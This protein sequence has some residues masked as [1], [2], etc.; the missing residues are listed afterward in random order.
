[1]SALDAVRAVI[2]AVLAH[3]LAAVE[4]TQPLDDDRPTLALAALGRRDVAGALDDLRDVRGSLRLPC[5]AAARWLEECD[6]ATEVLFRSAAGVALAG[7]LGSDAAAGAVV[8][9]LC[10][11]YDAARGHEALAPLRAF[12][13]ALCGAL[14]CRAEICAGYAPGYGIDRRETDLRTL[15]L[16]EAYEARYAQAYERRADARYQREQ[17]CPDRD[18]HYRQGWCACGYRRA[19]IGSDATF[20]ASIAAEVAREAAGPL[21][22]YDGE[23]ITAVDR[24]AAG[25]RSAAETYPRR[26]RGPDAV[27]GRTWGADAVGA[28]A[29]MLSAMRDRRALAACLRAAASQGVRPL[30][31]PSRER[32][33]RGD[34]VD[35]APRAETAEGR[36]W[37]F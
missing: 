2:R 35:V 21:A 9:T 22:G 8:D 1:M 27:A 5:L 13:A 10:A 16:D 29:Q 18:G 24:L 36:R 14:E 34:V 23:S 33:P 31:P 25:W 20:R 17:R 4:R 7:Y 19:V 3:L 30:P 32:R 28:W 11:D 26:L 12:A 37:T 6:D 15:C